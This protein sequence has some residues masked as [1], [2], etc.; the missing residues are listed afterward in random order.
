MMEKPGSLI[1]AS[2][3]VSFLGFFDARFRL[4]GVKLMEPYPES[5]KVAEELG[6]GV[7]MGGENPDD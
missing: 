2:F 3:L 7:K 5:P 4:G 1:S 6:D